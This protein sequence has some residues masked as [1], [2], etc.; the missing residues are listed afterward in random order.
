MQKIAI[1]LLIFCF[2]VFNSAA[3][4]T[5]L[6]TTVVAETLTGAP[7]SQVNIYGEFQYIVTIINSG[8]E[9]NNVTFSQTLSPSIF[10]QNATSQN[11]IGGATNVTNLSFVNNMLT[12]NV[13]NMPANSSVE[14]RVLV[15]AT[16]APGGIATTVIVSPPEGITDVNLSNNT[17]IISIDVIDVPLDFTVEYSQ[18]SPSEGT[19]ISNWGDAVMYNF[20]ITNNSSVTFPLSAFYGFIELE[21]SL[22]NGRPVVEFESL[23]CLG[24]TNGTDCPSLGNIPA[25]TEIIS[26]THEMFENTQSI[27]FSAG[28]T[29]TFQI[30]YRYVTPICGLEV[31]QLEVNSF[32]E[33]AF[34]VDL[35][36]E[37]N[38]VLTPLLEG[39][40]CPLTDICIETIQTDPV[41]SQMVNWSEEVTFVTTVC[42][43]GPED[44]T[45][46]F[47]LQNLNVSLEWNIIS[48]TC[49]S[50]TGNIS[51]NDFTITDGGQFWGTNNFYMPANTTIEVT[52]VVVFPDPELCKI[53]EQQN[54]IANI[55]SGTNILTPALTDIDFTN[56]VDYDAVIL[57]PFPVCDPEDITN[58]SITKTQIGPALPEGGAEDNTTDWGEITYEIVVTNSGNADVDIT[59]QDYMPE[60][61]IGIMQ[62]TLV[63]VDCIGTTG[64]AVC[65]TINNTNIGVPMDGIPEDGAEDVF[66]EI[67]SDD[68]WTLPAMSSITFHV[69]VNWEPEC[70]EVPI[71]AKN[72]VRVV[73]LSN[74]PEFNEDDN[75][76]IETT[77]FADCIDLLVQTYPETTQVS[78]NQSFNWVIDITNSNTSSSA[79]NIDFED[80]IGNQFAITGPPICTVISGNA[81]CP[82]LT[83]NGNTV[84]GEI[85]NMDGN[86]TMQIIIPVTAPSYGGAFTNMAEAIPNPDDNEEQT[87]ETNISISS[88]Q[89]IAPTIVKTFTPTEIIQGNISVLEFTVTNLPGNPAQTEINFTDNLPTGLELAGEIMW[90]QDN[91]CSATFIG[92]SGDIAVGV[93]NLSFPEGVASCI[94]SVPVT[95]NIVGNYVNNSTNF[96]DV[97]N[98][99]TTQANATLDVLLDTSDVDIE[100]LKAVSPVEASIGDEVVFT[101]TVTNLGT[102]SATDIMLYES[103]PEGYSYIEAYVSEG[104]YSTSSY[105]W[106]IE[107]LAAGQSETLTITALVVS[108]NN[109]LNTASLESLNEVDRDD[110]NNEDSAEVIVDNCLQIP[111]GFSPNGDGLN[112]V[113]IV[114]CIEDYPVNNIKIYSRYGN[115]VFETN[116]YK[117]NWN[118]IPNRGLPKTSKVLPAGTYYYVLSIDSIKNPFVSWIYLNR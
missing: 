83:V 8:N 64:T 93:S 23:T 105:F 39:E 76:A 49:N 9:V 10:Y 14:V 91:G 11:P 117:N 98:L 85:P 20:T 68:N 66:W 18:V 31:G 115:L 104:I 102:T 94:F 57:P 73:S 86:T 1:T 28:G 81:T 16:I 100:V 116:N 72:G 65:Q 90:V 118:G 51:C 59:L 88:V 69:V 33:L 99:D 101:I 34:G 58:I 7:I 106:D 80:I 25:N 71:K 17:S 42:N 45:I 46:R 114:P 61:S 62:G 35:T 103:L 40:L 89:V 19:G 37:S 3:Q 84:T 29:L 108:A 53:L 24:G 113:L 87:P 70:S 12:G 27:E 21:S 107:M 52:T 63:S 56:N 30:V 26:S 96:T 67:V 77:Y 44:A 74:N 43:N 22:V 48:I 4:T 110:T 6:A 41:P 2:S 82:T 78:V 5:D 47:F 109:L 75:I 54:S 55:K 50:T 32:I 95:S 13:A 79:I 60:N 112:D 15:N 111:E 92:Q 36:A 97:N 38:M